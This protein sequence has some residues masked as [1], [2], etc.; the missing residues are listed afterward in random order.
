MGYAKELPSGK[1]QARYRDPSGRGHKQ[2]FESERLAKKF[3]DRISADIQRDQWHD[4]R[5]GR[6]SVEKWVD[7]WWD[8]TLNLRASTR[9][10]YESIIDNR[11]L[12][13]FGSATLKSITPLQVRSWVAELSY[14]DIAPAT[15]R[16]IYNV[17]RKI[18]SSAVDSGFIAQSPCK[19]ISLPKIEQ[20]EMRFLS[21]EEVWRLADA[22]D[23]RY[24]ALVLLGAYSG[25]RWG[26]MA[27]LK[28]GKVD[29]MRGEV[30]VV[31]ILLDIDGKLSFGKP[32]T[33]A[34]RRKVGIP[35]SIVD[36]LAA[37]IGKRPDPE[38]DLV[39]QS[40]KGG[41]LRRSLFR[42][43]TWLPAIEKAGL[44]P[45][46]VHDLRHTAISFWIYAGAHVREIATRAGHTSASVVLDRYGH[47]FPEADIKLRDTLEAMA[48]SS[49]LTVPQPKDA[50][51]I[52]FKKPNANP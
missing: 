22:I 40:S 49:R 7:Q 14:E 29:L 23:P 26:E 41:P 2:S 15:V 39:F 20:E 44:S 8:T 27:G 21:P 33:R 10:R 19:G 1:W 51:V 47:I 17:F 48:T 28:T 25:L 18:M 46:R 24:R 34:G 3:L 38:S 50:D 52:P 5:L 16:K 4:P 13:A 35:R 45:L 9:A 37:H 32:K 36:E 31:E 30:D 43:R 12:P 6:M 11:I 42:R